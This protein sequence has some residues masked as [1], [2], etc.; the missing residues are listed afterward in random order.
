MISYKN[1]IKIKKQ[2]YLKL[3]K[4]YSNNKLRQ[5]SK[6]KGTVIELERRD[7]IIKGVIV[8][9]GASRTCRQYC[10][11]VGGGKKNIR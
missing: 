11:Y 1:R 6:I 5:Q 7:K 2:K 9:G 8:R 4:S 3:R 10:K